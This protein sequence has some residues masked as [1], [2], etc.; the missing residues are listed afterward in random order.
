MLAGDCGN[1][2]REALPDR[3]CQIS[4]SCSQ[5]VLQFHNQVEVS[6]SMSKTSIIAHVELASF[7]HVAAYGLFGP[8]ITPNRTFF[9]KK[10]W[11][12]MLLYY[13]ETAYEHGMDLF[14]D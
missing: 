7:F 1:N 10:S 12:D 4:E 5:M 8:F 9:A 11:S 3:I 13:L 2:I 6:K 14:T